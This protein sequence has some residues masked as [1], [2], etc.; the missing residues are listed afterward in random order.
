MTSFRPDY[1]FYGRRKG[2][3]L[4]RHH[5]TLMEGLLP[6][7]SVDLADPLRGCGPRR[8]LEIGF[9]GGEHLAHLASLHSDISMIGAEAFRNG[10]AKLLAHVEAKNARNVLIH[11]GDAR[12]LLAALPDQSMERIYLLYPDP[13]PKERQKRRR[14]V[15]PENLGQFH[16]VLKP[17]GQMFFAS[18]ISDY[19]AWTREQVKTHGGFAPVIDSVEPFENWVTTRFEAKAQ[20]A[21][22]QSCYLAY[23]KVNRALVKPKT[24]RGRKQVAALCWRMKRG[25]REVLLITSRET[26]RWVIPK[27]WPMA[28]LKDFNAAKTEAFEEAG[29]RGRIT[30]K[31]L[32]RFAY[33]KL[34]ENDSLRVT[35]TVYGLAV[36]QLL[37][38]WPEAKQRKREWYGL[39]DAAQLVGEE[40]LKDIIGRLG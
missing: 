32:G 13:W 30:R 15:N 40:G 21:G 2:K 19:V 39:E 16:R 14:F 11:Y 9:G 26:K 23:G 38:K 5:S 12:A 37:K 20:K 36:A 29:V 28:G 35:V 7:L 3:P 1:Q 22:R 27:G 24:R 10:V 8:W 17:G 33:D 31:P 6:S 4:R 34:L 25:K 18:D